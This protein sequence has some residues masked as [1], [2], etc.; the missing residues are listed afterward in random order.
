MMIAIQLVIS[1]YEVYLVGWLAPDETE[2]LD[3]LQLDELEV[4]EVLV[5]ID[6]EV[7]DDEQIVELVL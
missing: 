7:D 3:D 1:S 4:L 5:V 2:D 6:D